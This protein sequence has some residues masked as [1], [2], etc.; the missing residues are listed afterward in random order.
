MFYTTWQRHDLRQRSPNCGLESEWNHWVLLTWLSKTSNWVLFKEPD[1]IGNSV[2]NHQ[3]IQ[4]VSYCVS[5][6][7]I[8][9][10]SH[11]LEVWDW[12]V[13]PTVSQD[14]VLESRESGL[15]DW[16]EWRIQFIFSLSFLL[17][18]RLTNPPYFHWFKWGCQPGLKREMQINALFLFINLTFWIFLNKSSIF[19]FFFN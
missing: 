6:Q 1:D 5:V 17:Q 12:H 15:I 2:Q 13:W 7:R 16:V 14:S 19:F 10:E 8:T 3:L 4:R 9:E 11:V 18:P